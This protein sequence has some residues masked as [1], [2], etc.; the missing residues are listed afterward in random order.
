MVTFTGF[1]QQEFNRFRPEGWSCRYEAPIFS[2]DLEDALGFAARADILLQASDESRRYWIEFEVSRANPVAN[3]AKFAVGHLYQPQSQKDFFVSMVSSHVS[4]GRR[5]LAGNAIHS[6]R[7]VGMNAFQTILLPH[8]SGSE[9][10][11]WNGMSVMKLTSENIPIQDE[12]ER[13][14]AITE[15]VTAVGSRDIY[16]V[17]D[18]SDVILNVRR[19]NLDISTEQG[20][21]DFGRR[22][23]TYF[24]YDPWMK[25]FAPSKF[26][27]YS[28]I[29]SKNKVRDHAY[30][31]D[32]HSDM[33]ISFYSQL[34]ESNPAFDGRIA[35]LHLEKR[36]A[37]HLVPLANRPD[38]KTSFYAWH[39]Y[40]APY[41]K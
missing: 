11:R 19:F 17:G 26:C 30:P 23:V 37:M 34:D 10:K 1:L 33:T 14:F 24:V 22:T 6:M 35:R 16:L 15:P 25:T 29:N 41:W 8:S 2:K 31:T 28:V 9:I 39:D 27:A 20:C 38:L 18:I 7:C 21:S 3:H 32:F 5:N 4:R 40:S 12:I 13:V 36:L